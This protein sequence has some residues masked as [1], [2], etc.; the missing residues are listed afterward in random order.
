MR[1]NA[2]RYGT[3]RDNKRKT[4]YV[5]IGMMAVILINLTACT[6]YIPGSEDEGFSPTI[7]DWPE[8]TDTIRTTTD[9]GRDATHEDS[10]RLGLLPPE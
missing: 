7:K 1:C 4:I 3:N 6:H 9:G 2:K 8:A 5:F 10:I